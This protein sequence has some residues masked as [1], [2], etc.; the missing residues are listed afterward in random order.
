MYRK[1]CTVDPDTR[2]ADAATQLILRTWKQSALTLKAR[3]ARILNNNHYPNVAREIIASIS[4]YGVTTPQTGMRFPSAGNNGEDEISAT[5][6]I[7]QAI[8]NVDASNPAIDPIRQWL[9]I[10][11]GLQN[12]GDGTTATSTIAAI[13]TTSP[14]WIEA[15]KGSTIRLG[16][17]NT[18]IS[19]TD[20]LT[21]ETEFTVSGRE[22]SGKRLSIRRESD[23]PAWGAVYTRATQSADSVT[24]KP[25]DGLSIE[26]ALLTEEGKT[27]TDTGTLHTGDKVTVRLT[28]KSTNELDYMVITDDR[29]SCLEPDGQLSGMMSVDGLSFYRENRDTQTRIFIDHL[30]RGTYIL[31]YPM[32]VN[33]SGE[34]ISGIAT[35]QSQYAPRYT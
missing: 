14:R 28:I 22:A 18:A 15:V 23:T 2:I 4:Q 6:L 11:K 30:P 27:L 5:A 20:R 7:L 8:H 9:I 33:N 21:G 35:I 26:K 16:N 10:Q 3:Y 17:S 19:T 32:W 1:T 12:W 24:P 31:T 13:L 29:A 25:C 34:C